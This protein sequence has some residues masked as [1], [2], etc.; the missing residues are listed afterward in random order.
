MPGTET[1]VQSRRDNRTTFFGPHKSVG[2]AIRKAPPIAVTC[3]TIYRN[4]SS[5]GLNPN[6]VAAKILEKTITVFTPSSYIRYDRR[7][8][9]CSL[10]PRSLSG[11]VWRILT[12][13]RMRQGEIYPFSCPVEEIERPVR[14]TQRIIPKPSAM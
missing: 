8:F 6:V 14:R 10:L 1:D 7:N 9:L 13:G 12:L 3:T 4:I 11:C 2:F 5:W